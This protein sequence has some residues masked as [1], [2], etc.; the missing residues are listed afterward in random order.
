MFEEVGERLEAARGCTDSDNG[1]GRTW[2]R[3]PNVVSGGRGA[4]WRRRARCRRA[5]S[6]AFT[7]P[8]APASRVRSFL[9]S[10][11]E[12]RVHTRLI[13]ARP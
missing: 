6:G 11:H 10:P 7:R 9:R 1:K 5:A 3:D 13:S 12:P 4:P 8:R 2:C